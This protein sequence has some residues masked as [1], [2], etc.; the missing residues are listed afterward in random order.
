MTEYDFSP[1][2]Y[3]HYI[4]GQHKIASWVSRT[5]RVPKADPYQA[6]T[7]AFDVPR[8]LLPEDRLRDPNAPW[9]L[10]KDKAKKAKKRRTPSEKEFDRERRNDYKYSHREHMDALRAAAARP[11]AHRSQTAPVQR[12]RRTSYD[13]AAPKPPPLQNR[14]LHPGAMYPAGHRFSDSQDTSSSS[15][16]YGLQYPKASH[17]Q[18]RSASVQSPARALPGPMPTGPTPFYVYG[19]ENNSQTDMSPHTAQQ[20]KPTRS[21]TV[22][23]PPPPASAPVYPSPQYQQQHHSMSHT[24]PQQPLQHRHR[25]PVYPHSYAPSPLSPPDSAPAYSGGYPRTPAPVIPK[26][27]KLEMPKARPANPFLQRV[28]MHMP[29]R[30]RVPRMHD[31]SPS[32]TARSRSQPPSQSQSPPRAPTQPRTPTS[33]TKSSWLGSPTKNKLVKAGRSRASLDHWPATGAADAG[34]GEDERGWFRPSLDVNAVGDKAK[35]RGMS[36][37][38]GDKD[39]E[40]GRGKSRARDAERDLGE[41]VKEKKDREKS[42]RRDRSLERD[43]D[44]DRERYDR[45]RR[46]RPA[47]RERERS[48]DRDREREREREHDREKQQTPRPP[49]SKDKKEAKETQPYRRGSS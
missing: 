31:R 38:V 24:F 41:S 2:A 43:R 48:F 37:R 12:G 10:P 40:R 47:H 8:E 29:G 45:D 36:E 7:P 11:E 16:T 25:P 20:H 39:K 30:T 42:R 22:P 27:P 46:S 44:K 28:L 1:E 6:A 32:P 21:Q 18:K 5:N 14:S 9:L 15:D 17:K 26:P 35:E 23:L 13:E 19:A 4:Q 34:W 3:E 33:P 49:R